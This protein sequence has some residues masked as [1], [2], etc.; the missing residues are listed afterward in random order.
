[1]LVPSLFIHHE[2]RLAN[3][4]H[5]EEEVMA[6][7]TAA[8]STLKL[9]LAENDPPLRRLLRETL[10]SGCGHQIL[11]EAA[12]GTDLVHLALALDPEVIVFDLHL[13]GCSGLDALRQISQER[14]V[15]AVALAAGGDQALIR[16][17]L[18]HYDMTYL[19]KP[20]EPHQ[21]EPAVLAAWAKFN[22]VR[23]LSDENATLRQ[24]LQ[25]RKLIERAK[26]VLMRRHRWS[27]GEA[28]RRLQRGAMNRRTTIAQLAQSVLD[29]GEIDLRDSNHDHRFRF[30]EG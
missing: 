18:D 21:L 16:R 19:V 4:H 17:V 26:G 29:G 15:A 28:Y 7:A 6:V 1:L 30:V 5:G 13:P 3:G 20:F 25:N 9:V 11:G 12:T 27:E 2:A 23:Q 24:T 10:E 22:R 8:V 14:G